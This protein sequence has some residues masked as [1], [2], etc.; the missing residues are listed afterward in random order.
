MTASLS[1]TPQ[2]HRQITD[3]EF[4]GAW[5]EFT[6]PTTHRGKTDVTLR[7]RFDEHERIKKEGGRVLVLNPSRSDAFPAAMSGKN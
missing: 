1:F 4:A 5:V 2:F 6:M 7:A 3:G